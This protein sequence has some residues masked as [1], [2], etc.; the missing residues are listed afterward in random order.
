M[1]RSHARSSPIAHNRASSTS[2]ACA[3]S[4][5]AGTPITRFYRR[6]ETADGRL[7]LPTETADCS[8]F[9]QRRPPRRR[10]PLG[11]SLGAHLFPD[12]RDVPSRQRGET[13]RFAIVTVPQRAAIIGRRA[14]RV[15]AGPRV[16]EHV[17]PLE[18]RAV[19]GF[20][21]DEI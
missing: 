5:K 15:A 6:T 16:P 13:F 2:A 20:L 19:G 11:R 10:L 14:A 4:T 1:K 12:I 9:P 8:L 17:A 18:V 21:E 3:E 7:R